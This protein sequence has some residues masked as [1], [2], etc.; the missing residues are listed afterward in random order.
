[1][2]IILLIEPDRVLGR[3]FSDALVAR[4]HQVSVCATAQSGIFRADDVQPDLVL[5]ELQL[6]GHSGIEFLYE[7]RSYPDWQDVPV[8]VFSNVPAKEFDHNWQQI[9]RQLAVSDYLYK[10]AT[11]L[12]ALLAV[13]DD[14]LRIPTP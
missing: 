7:F 1:M 4:G 11:S 13:I 5:V 9:K 2:A 3:T 14:T 8:I 12:A 6:V 10:P